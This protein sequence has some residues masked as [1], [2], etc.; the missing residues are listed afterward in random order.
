[1]HAP[2]F[3]LAALLSLASSTLAS[4][5]F[6][7]GIRSF[8][9]PYHGVEFLKARTLGTRGKGGPN[10]LNKR[11][12]R[13]AV[14]KC[15]SSKTFQ[16][17]DGDRCT[18][19]GSVAAG[20]MCKDGAITWDTTDEASPQDS[21][22]AS[23][24]MAAIT[25]KIE[26]IEASPST[27][28]AA[29]VSSSSVSAAEVI[30]PVKQNAVQTNTPSLTTPAVSS[31]QSASSSSSGDDEEDWEC[32]ADDEEDSS[33]SS[34]WSAPSSTYTPSQ[35]NPTTSVAP[36]LAVKPK[37]SSTTT[38][39]QA[40]SSTSAPEPIVSAS[41]SV[42]TGSG[43]WI[44]G[45]KATF[46]Y[47]GGGYGACGKIHQDSEFGVALALDRYGGSSNSNPDCGK[48]LL[49]KNNAN[50]KTV[51]GQVWDAC[52]GCANYNSLDLSVA[53]FDAIGDQATGV[54]E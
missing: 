38:T 17:C 42:D 45:G 51:K 10:R 4:G 43:D 31:T 16:L 36:Q 27:S 22:K 30:V 48:T 40:P 18:D 25:S 50:G 35:S 39:T 19:M 5:H 2:L 54:L 34:S 37:S 14:L 53:A 26:Q 32:E 20:T 12:G 6:S 33:S 13:E 44:T 8:S 3:S 9:P 52:P 29:A 21:S 1:M 7:H 41:V 15:T 23:S 46:F 11:G 24:S 28:K 47:Q 49:I